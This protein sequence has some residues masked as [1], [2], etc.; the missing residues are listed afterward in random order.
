MLLYNQVVR[1]YSNWIFDL[2]QFYSEGN[3]AYSYNRK[4]TEGKRWYE[5]CEKISHPKVE[6]Q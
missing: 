1:V 2:N 3:N 6:Y 5:G 4:Y